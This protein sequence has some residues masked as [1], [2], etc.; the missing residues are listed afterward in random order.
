MVCLLPVVAASARLDVAP[1]LSAMAAV[2]FAV[3][4]WKPVAGL[5]ILAGLLPLATPLSLLI[6]A[7]LDGAAAAEFIVLAFLAAAGMRM[8]FNRSPSS[9]SLT[10]PLLA[11]VGVVASAVVVGLVAEQL[12]TNVPLPFW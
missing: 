10:A 9:G 8:G 7:P 5:A 3:T 2:I 12:R 4:L 6:A 11:R 1:G